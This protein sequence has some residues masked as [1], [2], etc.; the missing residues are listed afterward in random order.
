MGIVA[1]LLVWLAWDHLDK[2]VNSALDKKRVRA[3]GPRPRQW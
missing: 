1:A 2:F 3:Q